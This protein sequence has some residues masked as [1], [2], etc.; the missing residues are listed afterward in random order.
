MYP[1]LCGSDGDAHLLPNG[2]AS[3]DALGGLRITKSYRRLRRHV[4][5]VSP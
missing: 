2:I 5:Q 4:K 1:S 3:C